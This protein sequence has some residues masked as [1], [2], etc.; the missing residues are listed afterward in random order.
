MHVENISCLIP[1]TPT[2]GGVFVGNIYGAKNPGVLKEY[3]IRGVITLVGHET[4]VK[5]DP[6]DIP[7]HLDIHAH[8]KADF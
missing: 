3:G 1:E 4:T 2:Q 5:Y 8:D 7:F 6:K